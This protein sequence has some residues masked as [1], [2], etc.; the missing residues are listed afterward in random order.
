VEQPRPEHNAGVRKAREPQRAAANG[1]RGTTGLVREGHIRR[2]PLRALRKEEK[3]KF[4]FV[5]FKGVRTDQKFFDGK[6]YVFPYKG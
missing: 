3:H 1:L 6:K 5:F 2:R 4:E